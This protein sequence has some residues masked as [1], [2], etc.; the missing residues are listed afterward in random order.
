MATS[1]SGRRGP[2]TLSVNLEGVTLTFPDGK[3]VLNRW[4]GRLSFWQID[5]YREMPTPPQTPPIQGH[6]VLDW[7][8]EVWLTGEEIDAIL[9]AARRAGRRVDTLR[10]SG[11]AAAMHRHIVRHFIKPPPLWLWLT[12]QGS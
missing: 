2:F 4:P 8:R 10:L 6:T 7:F 1:T 9:D 5:D 12:F 11:R 3:T